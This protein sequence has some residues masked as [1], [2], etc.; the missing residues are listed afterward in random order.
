[1]TDPLLGELGRFTSEVVREDQLAT[2]LAK[3]AAEGRPLR[4]KFGIDPTFT[5]VHLGHSVPIRVLR[6][7]QRHGHL[8]L[9]VPL[10][11]SLLPQYSMPRL[12]V[13]NHLIRYAMRHCPN[14][15]S[16]CL[17]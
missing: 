2:M 8:P 11:Y 15:L 5:D 4:V 12:V 13:A 7:F 16:S 1:M 10:D 17:R 6:L 14:P 3:S 9:L